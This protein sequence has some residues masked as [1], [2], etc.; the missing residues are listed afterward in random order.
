MNTGSPPAVLAE[1]LA[2]SYASGGGLTRADIALD[3]G[4]MAA[5]EGPP[6]RARAPCLPSSD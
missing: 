6:A 5:V 4:V 2:F 3:A 1:G